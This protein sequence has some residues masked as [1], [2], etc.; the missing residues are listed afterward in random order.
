MKSPAVK[1]AIGLLL[2]GAILGG[3]L[4]ALMGH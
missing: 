4:I 1:L 2:A 3:D